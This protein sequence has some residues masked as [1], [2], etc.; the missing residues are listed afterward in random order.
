MVP[1]LTSPNPPPENRSSKSDVVIL[2]GG[3][4]TRLQSISSGLPKALMPISGQPFLGLLLDHLIAS[5]FKR[6][7]FC[8]G[9]GKEKI[10]DY[11]KSYQDQN[12]SQPMVFEFAE[13][14]EPLGTGGALKLA[15]PHI[16]SDN[17]FVLN[18]DTFSSVNFQDFYNF[19]LSNKPL[20]SIALAETNSAVSDFGS[21][22]VGENGN[23]VSFEEKKISGSGFMNAGAYLMSR[24]IF[25]RMTASKFSLETDFFPS[26]VNSNRFFGYSKGIRFLDIGTPERYREAE[27]LMP[28]IMES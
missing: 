13:E 18:G 1:P 27:K 28:R 23:I 15:A 4:G 3:L 24:E 12:R 26:L 20:V 14:N 10:L 17:F 8:L 16:K 7:T 19:H 25:S 6:V 9:Y 22:T 11:L 21:I 5:N 2:C